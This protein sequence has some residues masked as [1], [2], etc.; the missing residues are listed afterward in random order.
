MLAVVTDAHSVSHLPYM[1]VGVG[2][3]R[4]GWAPPELVLNTRNLQGIREF[5]L[6]KRR[7]LAKA[8]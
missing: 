4:R 5:V 6:A 3:A 8:G 7:K 2:I 1:K